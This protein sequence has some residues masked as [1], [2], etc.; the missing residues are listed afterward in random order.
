MKKTSS[1][2]DSH[3]YRCFLTSVS[4]ALPR[5]TPPSQI[6]LQFHRNTEAQKY[7]FLHATCYTLVQGQSLIAVRGGN[8][9]GL[10]T[11]L[12]QILEAEKINSTDCQDALQ[13]ERERPV[14]SGKTKTTKENFLKQILEMAGGIYDGL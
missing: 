1:R 3:K 10:V 7:N 4:C 9:S 11:N 8:H 5:R 2:R 14:K 12:S 6:R 13:P